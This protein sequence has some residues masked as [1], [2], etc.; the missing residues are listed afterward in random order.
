MMLRG[1]AFSCFGTELSF[2]MDEE[3]ESL[4]RRHTQG[5]SIYQDSIASL[6]QQQDSRIITIIFKSQC[7]YP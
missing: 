2:A 7:N 1:P 5:Y 6:T 4:D 3:T